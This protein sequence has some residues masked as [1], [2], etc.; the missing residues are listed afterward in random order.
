MRRVVGLVL[1]LAGVPAL[2]LAQNCFHP[3]PAPACGSFWILEASTERRDGRLA[4][5]ALRSWEILA[6]G[7]LGGMVNVSPRWAVGGALVMVTRGQEEPGAAAAM[8]R[9]GAV[10]RGRRWLGSA[11]SVEVSAGL[12]QLQGTKPMVEVAVE[13]GGLVGITLGA[14]G[15]GPW[16]GRGEGYLGLRYSSYAAVV[17]AYVALMKAMSSLGGD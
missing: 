4:G 1:S 3:R 16:P 7:A 5:Q 2:V 12:W 14:R 17:A 15:D 11:A 8:S 13:V 10:V 6:S 9:V